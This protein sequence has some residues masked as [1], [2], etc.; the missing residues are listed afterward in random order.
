MYIALRRT[1]TRHA[2]LAIAFLFPSRHEAEKY[3]KQ[4]HATEFEIPLCTY[5]AYIDLPVK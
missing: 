5:V 2:W 3:L 4:N 1:T